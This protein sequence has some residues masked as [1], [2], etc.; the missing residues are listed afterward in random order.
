MTEPRRKYRPPEPGPL[1]LRE[2]V[3]RALLAL[4]GPS[5]PDAHLE[6]ELVENV[7]RALRCELSDEVL[8]C[9]A[10]GDDTLPEWGF[11][12]GE[13][14]DH[15]AWARELGC[16][17]DMIAVGRH[18]GSHVLYCI[19]RRGD[20]RRSVGLVEF[21]VEGNGDTNWRDLGEWLAELA[22]LEPDA[23]ARRSS[24]IVQRSLF[25]DAEAPA[26]SMPRV[27]QLV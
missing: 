16:R 12:L 4:V 27:W 15:T 2:S 10:N 23:C 6:T 8:A 17:P 26:E 9:F 1:H 21:E 3:R 24:P 14:A 20:R 7:E 5:S 11:R 13:V 22:G 25:E 19:G 18:P